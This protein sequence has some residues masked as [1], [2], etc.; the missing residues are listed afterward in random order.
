MLD[1]LFWVAAIA[2]I[3]EGVYMSRRVT[4]LEQQVQCLSGEC[5]HEEEWTEDQL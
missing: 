3:V 5:D 2:F 1:I 4:K